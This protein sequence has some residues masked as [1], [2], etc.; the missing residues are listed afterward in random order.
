[1][2]THGAPSHSSKRARAVPVE[3][4]F[5]AE[6]GSRLLTT[7]VAA[8]EV[9]DVEAVHLLQ[10]VEGLGRLHEVALTRRASVEIPYPAKFAQCPCNVEV[11]IS[12]DYRE[13]Q[14]LSSEGPFA[15]GRGK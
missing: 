12:R 2:P 14:S 4:V 10:S 11:H 7:D 9:A 15:T 6:L 13:H 1:M 5:H 8:H 3:G